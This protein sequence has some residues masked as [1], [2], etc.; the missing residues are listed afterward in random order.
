MVGMYIYIQV[1]PH[2]GEE[3]FSPFFDQ[4]FCEARLMWQAGQ[5]WQAGR[6]AGF[7]KTSNLNENE[8]KKKI[9]GLV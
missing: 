7:E 4:V 5:A 3:V 9:K 8:K 1:N 2:E 6:P